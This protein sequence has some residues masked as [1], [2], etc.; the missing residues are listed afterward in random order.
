[1]SSARLRVLKAMLFVACLMP[2]VGMVLAVFGRLGLSLGANPVEE[3]IH[4]NGE[5]GL[6]FLLITL[7]VTPLR[8]M[9]VTFLKLVF[10]LPLTVYFTK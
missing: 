6:R 3:L 7:A 8:R 4:E 5:W 10:V 9:S 1:M 2:F